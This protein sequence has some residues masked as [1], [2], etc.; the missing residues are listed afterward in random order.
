MLS[1]VPRVSRVSDPIEARPAAGAARLRRRPPAWSFLL[2]AIALAVAACGST[3]GAPGASPADF[4]TIVAAFKA[5]G[6]G[7]TGV[8]SGDAGCSDPTLVPASISFQAAGLDQ[9]AAVTVH[10]Y[11][12]GNGSAYSRLRS[13]VDA[14]V[15]SYVK[16]PSAYVAVDVSPY[17]VAGSGPWGK[18]FEAALRSGLELAGSPQLNGQ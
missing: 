12:F 1:G 10:L 5:Q 18:R 9:T 2:A 4:S 14:C 6:I 13:E 17:V 16:N 7:V 8:V 11:R 15:R 3:A